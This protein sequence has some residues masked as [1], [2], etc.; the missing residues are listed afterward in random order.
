MNLPARW[1][2][3][4]GLSRL[5]L[6][7]ATLDDEVWVGIRSACQA[8]RPV[9]AIFLLERFAAELAL[10]EVRATPVELL[11]HM[12]AHPFLAGR[13]RERFLTG[14]DLLANTPVL[15]LRA[16]ADAPPSHLAELVTASL[17]AIVGSPVSHVA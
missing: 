13:E 2:S 17:P 5:G 10:E 9:A 8:P 6:P 1:G 12:L 11:G 7:I 3:D 4:G 15:R 16:P 14:C